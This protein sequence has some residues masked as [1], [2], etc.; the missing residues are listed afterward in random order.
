MGS[1][2]GATLVDGATVIGIDPGCPAC[3]GPPAAMVVEVPVD[4]WWGGADGCD[5]A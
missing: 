4:G 1:G 2:L 3:E 5:G